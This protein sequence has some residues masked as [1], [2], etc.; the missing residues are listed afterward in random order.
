MQAELEETRA[1]MKRQ[2]CDIEQLTADNERLRGKLKAAQGLHTHS[3]SHTHTRKGLLTLTHTR[4][5]TRTHRRVLAE[6]QQTKA[7]QVICI[8]SACICAALGTLPRHQ[9]SN[10]LILGHI[11][12]LRS[13]YV[14]EAYC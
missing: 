9:M 5:H 13:T 14:D 12:V 7:T 3:H 2:S 8:A 4:A 6:T 1:E 11:A 10:S